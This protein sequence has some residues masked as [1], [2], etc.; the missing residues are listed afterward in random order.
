[1]FTAATAEKYLHVIY[2]RL[3]PAPAMLSDK[4]NILLVT[5]E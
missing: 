1:M 3:F 5:C 4:L 2:V